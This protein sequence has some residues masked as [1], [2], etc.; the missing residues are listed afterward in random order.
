[1]E[2]AMTQDKSDAQNNEEHRRQPHEKPHDRGSREGDP[3]A[4]TVIPGREF[5]AGGGVD[6]GPNDAG[7]EETGAP[8]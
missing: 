7:G 4:D 8:T 3:A 6:D 2:S 1:M 5:G